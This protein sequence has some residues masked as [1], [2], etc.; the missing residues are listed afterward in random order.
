VSDAERYRMSAKTL[1]FR[2]TDEMLREF[3]EMPESV[4]NTRIV[5][6]RCKAEM[7]LGGR[8][9]PAFP[10]KEE[11]PEE[12]FGR[13][14]REGVARLYPTVGPDVIARLDYEIATIAKM[15]FIDY[16]LIVQDFIAHARSKDIP[17]GPGRGS[18]AGSIVAYALGITK[19]DPLKYDLLFERFL[20]AERI[21][22]PDI[23]IDFCF[24]RRK[25]VIDY[26]NTKYGKERVAQIVTFGTLK[27][28]AAIRDVGRVLDMPLPEV[29]RIAKKIPNGP[30]DSLSESV[31]KDEEVK[32]V[33]EENEATRKVFEIGLRL[34][35]CRR[36]MSTHAAGV[37]IS[38]A[39]LVERVPLCTTGDDVVTQWTMDALEDVG[40]LKMD[41]LGLAHVDD[42]RLRA[43]QR[44]VDDRTRDRDR[45]H[46][47]DD[48]KTYR[49]LQEG[50]ASGV[51]QLESSGMIELLKKMR[52]D[53]FEDIIAILALYRPG[54]PDRHG[55]RLR[56]PQART[57]ADLLQ[58]CASRTDPEGDVRR[59][60][61]P[62]TGHAHRERAFRVLA[63][64]SRF[65][66]Q[67]DG[68]EEA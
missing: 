52:P 27:A 42:H 3:P 64:R 5:A 41:F 19:L 66:P 4:S 26:V 20:N 13:L 57:R 55:R 34:E 46:P 54:P 38:D 36:N 49:L 62:G 17:V 11:T 51:F 59:H 63:E 28:R 29:D 68:Q 14:C 18:A 24:E 25:E 15:G 21:S 31:E 43:A 40:L 47:L 56:R 50:K 65:A 33:R 60:P 6:D 9:L 61:V 22:M 35:G 23:D 45:P 8:F 58:A 44:E 12:R 30:N 67:G 16:F 32:R 1:H 7:K 48:P 10:V 37:V 2:T 53:R 39:P